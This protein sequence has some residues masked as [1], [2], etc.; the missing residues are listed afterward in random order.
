MLMIGTFWR[1]LILTAALP[2][3]ML[4]AASPAMAQSPCDPLA[5]CVPAG[6]GCPDFNLGLAGTGGNLHYKEFRHKN[7][8]LVR[9]LSAG[10]GVL[11]TYTNYGPDPDNPVAGKSISIRTDGSVT[12]T[13]FNPDGTYTVTATGHNGLIMF[14]SDVPAGP[15]ATQYTG[16]F[17]YTVD[18]NTGVFTLDPRTSGT[19]RDI[20]AELA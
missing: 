1:Q 16:R 13:R 4:T 7:G 20:C 18:P 9:T 5:G 2:A 19:Q 8:N 14:P 17:V 12:S 3:L 6:L 15:T 10:K 11:L